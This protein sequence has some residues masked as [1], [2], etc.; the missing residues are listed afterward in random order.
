MEAVDE[1]HG[2]HATAPSATRGCGFCRPI[3]PQIQLTPNEI[4]SKK[5]GET[6]EPYL[7]N[8]NSIRYTIKLHGNTK[9]QYP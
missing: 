2:S 7:T 8:L 4:F 1:Q 6:V 9:S 3:T 5:H